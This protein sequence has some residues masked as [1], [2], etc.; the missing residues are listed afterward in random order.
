MKTEPVPEPFRRRSSILD[1]F[2]AADRVAP[3]AGG[4]SEDDPELTASPPFPSSGLLLGLAIVAGTVVFLFGI[5][6]WTVIGA[7]GGFL[8]L[9]VA[10]AALVLCF[11][12]AGTLGRLALAAVT[13]VLMLVVGLMLGAHVYDEKYLGDEAYSPFWDAVTPVYVLLTLAG[14]LLIPVSVVALIVVAIVR[15]VRRG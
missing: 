10:V 9:A 11:G 5:A 8:G 1:D 2:A 3:V 6:A 13:G 7:V 15:S 12:R 14:A 4:P